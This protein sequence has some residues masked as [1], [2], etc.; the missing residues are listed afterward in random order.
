[1]WRGNVKVYLMIYAISGA[2]IEL[3]Y[4]IATF[5]FNHL[6]EVRNR[7][8][9]TK[10][11]THGDDNINYATRT[12]QVRSHITH[13]ITD[14]TAYLSRTTKLH[15]LFLL[16]LLISLCNQSCVNTK[17]QHLF[18]MMMRFVIKLAPN[19]LRKWID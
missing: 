18:H 7:G 16:L 11:R 2:I 3:N 10:L 8:F 6:C 5:Y 9:Y 1:M 13:D 19:R 15:F 17:H 12:Q 4:T 14:K